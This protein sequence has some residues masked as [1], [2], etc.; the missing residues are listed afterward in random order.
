MS[1]K[2]KTAEQRLA[3]LEATLAALA[4]VRTGPLAAAYEAPGLRGKNIGG[5]I[6]RNYTWEELDCKPGSSIILDM[7]QGSVAMQT[8]I[9]EEGVVIKFAGAPNIVRRAWVVP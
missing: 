7:V 1:N 2:K 6:T 5:G 3:D 4:A 8:H 9:T